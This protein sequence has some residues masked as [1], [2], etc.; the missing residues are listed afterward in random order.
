MDSESR[1]WD[2]RELTPFPPPAL[3]HSSCPSGGVCWLEQLCTHMWLSNQASALAVRKWEEREVGEGW[4]ITR[5]GW[6]GCGAPA[7]HRILVCPCEQ[8][9][10]DLAP[11]PAGSRALGVGD[12]LECSLQ[13]PQPGLEKAPEG[14]ASPPQ[15]LLSQ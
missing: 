4:I 14:E 7:H 11:E 1:L 5:G 15:P 10:R 2:R 6:L 9:R 13:L 12:H 8:A 3:L